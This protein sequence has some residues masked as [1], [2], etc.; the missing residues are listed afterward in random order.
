MNLYMIQISFDILNHTLFQLFKNY[1][2]IV[3]MS[4][5]NLDKEKTYVGY[6]SETP[7]VDF[8]INLKKYKNKKPGNFIL[9]GTL[10]DKLPDKTRDIQL[11]AY[12]DA[13]GE[14]YMGFILVCNGGKSE[15][16][17]N[18][19]TRDREKSESLMRK[20]NEL[21]YNSSLI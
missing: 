12:N 5:V 21:I 3:F 8:N 15:T 10:L 20:A 4:Y 13:A 19:N 6:F 7:L 18:E 2:S 14:S 17:V 11:I 1:P 16:Y 9:H